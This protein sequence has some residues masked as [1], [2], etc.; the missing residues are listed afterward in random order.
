M[1]LL[2]LVQS[3]YWPDKEGLQDLS[4]L[5]ESEVI[6]LIAIVVIWEKVTIA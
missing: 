2:F 6:V 5:S 1:L 3:F 4:G